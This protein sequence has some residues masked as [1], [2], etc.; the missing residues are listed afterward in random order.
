MRDELSHEA[1][2]ALRA[3]R[4]RR[5]KM[6]RRRRIAALGILILIAAAVSSVVA[7]LAGGTAEPQG[8]TTA[9]RH[10]SQAPT[11]PV[12]PKE[13]R[14]VHVSMPLAAVPGKLDSYLRMRNHG[15]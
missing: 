13:I 8:I 1:R 6:V 14:G 11:F 3:R 10:E 4:E 15:L 7:A 2:R 12:R 9:V 5:R